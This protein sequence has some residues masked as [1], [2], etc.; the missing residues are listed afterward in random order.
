MQLLYSP[1]DSKPDEITML[2]FSCGNLLSYWSVWL[3]APV[4][5]VMIVVIR[6]RAGEIVKCSS[7]S[8]FDRDLKFAS[9]CQAN[10][11]TIVVSGPLS[12]LRA[13]LYWPKG[14]ARYLVFDG[15]RKVSLPKP[16]AVYF[17]PLPIIPITKFKNKLFQIPQLDHWVILA[18]GTLLKELRQAPEDVLSF[19]EAAEEVRS[20]MAM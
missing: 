8:V 19:N 10:V 1:S 2:S 9:L 15:Y 20:V 11:P 17:S 4:F 13:A 12:F 16:K 14:K 5:L 18:S 6:L 7:T 3:S